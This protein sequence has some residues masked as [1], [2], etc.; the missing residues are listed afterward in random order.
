[1]SEFVRLSVVIPV[2]NVSKFLPK[3]LD[4]LM[5]Q[6]LIP[7]EIIAVDDG[8]TDQ[9][10][11]ILAEYAK[12]MPNLRIIQ[13]ENGGISVARNTGLAL[14]RGKWLAFVDSDDFL[15][16][17][18]FSIMVSAAEA[19]DLDITISNAWYYFEDRSP[20]RCIYL[21]V[22]NEGVMTGEEWL[23][24][25]LEQGQ[26]AHMVWMHIYR[27]SMLEEKKI[28]F[29]PNL[30]H[31]DVV[32]TT[33]VLLSVRRVKYI[34][35]PLYHYRTV[36]RQYDEEIRIRRLQARL[37]SS[38]Y[39]AKALEVFASRYTRH[40]RTSKAIRWQLVDGGFSVF[41]LI[42]RLAVHNLQVERHRQLKEEGYYCLLWQ[43]AVN[44]R[45]KLKVLRRYL[46]YGVLGR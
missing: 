42:E 24:R 37:D 21:D 2:H 4:S 39:N 35:Q 36:P 28:Q 11:F 22:V 38:L 44:W 23:C 7:D 17:E 14:A 20:E 15:D 5:Y 18:A 34:P 6:T 9:S 25:R 46:K 32:W 3:C 27:R 30:I 45:Q 33:D 43:N 31:E 29:V 26:L 16:S 19:N 12:K 41:H 10:P 40:S 1:M 13:Q 8:S